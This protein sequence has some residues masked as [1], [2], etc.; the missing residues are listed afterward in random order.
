MAALG[1]GHRPVDYGGVAVMEGSLRRAKSAEAAI[2]RSAA[3]VAIIETDVARG[4]GFVVDPSGYLIT[5]RHVIEDADHIEGVVFPARDPSRVYGSVRVVYMDPL[6]DL[7]L[8]HVH[9]SEP[10]TALTLATD[11]VEPVSRYLAPADPVVLVERDPRGDPH[12]PSLEL[13]HGE[14]SR[15]EV[16]N[17]AAGPGPFLGVTPDVRQG[18]SGGPVLDRHGRA[19]GVVTWTW[20]KQGGGYAIPIADATRMLAERPNLELDA[21]REQRAEQRARAFLDAVARADG[22]AARRVTSPSQARKQREAVVTEIMGNAQ[23]GDGLALVQ[24][25]IVALEDLVDRVRRGEDPEIAQAGLGPLVVGMARPSARAVLGPDLEVSQVISFFQELGDAYLVARVFGGETSEDALRTA[26]RR[27]ATIDA[28]RSFALAA[29]VS[30]LHGR[31]LDIRAVELLPGAYMPGARVELVVGSAE[32]P[33]QALDLHLRLEWG[34][35]YV[36]SI[37]PAAV[38]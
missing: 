9:S 23:E 2:Q 30:E 35:W 18:Q 27:L 6:H 21:L 33:E 16:W 38:D 1:C 13:R 5:N 14:V 3:A 7:A 12:G 11:G 20:R 36:A 4:M 28:A 25:F 32:A 19:V 10:L 22:E 15:L 26:L 17:P 24:G 31:A 37:E 8:L 29:L 34:D